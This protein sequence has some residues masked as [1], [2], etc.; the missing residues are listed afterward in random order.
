MFL[1]KLRAPTIRVKR[2]HNATLRDSKPLHI[3]ANLRTETLF[4]TDRAAS[5]L[6]KSELE[7]PW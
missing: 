1:R 6:D 2:I 7:A 5:R 4:A 3:P